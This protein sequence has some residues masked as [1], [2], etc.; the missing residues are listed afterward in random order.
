MV[1][2]F[3]GEKYSSC[4]RKYDNFFLFEEDK[5][6]NPLFLLSK[7]F[8]KFIKLPLGLNELLLYMLLVDVNREDEEKI[9]FNC[10]FL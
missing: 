4:N 8:D 7:G 5:D 2:I 10:F 9:R 6:S 3:R 1:F